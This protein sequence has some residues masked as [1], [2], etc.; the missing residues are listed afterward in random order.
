MALTKIK[1]TGLDTGITDN[2]DANAITIDSSERVG[3]GTTGPATTLEV[4]NDSPTNGVQLSLT[5]QGVGD[6]GIGFLQYGANSAVIVNPSGTNDIAF[7][8][9]SYHGSRGNEKMRI[10]LT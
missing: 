4:W 9:N 10:K 7:E 2:S 3:I 8:N 5:R 1:R 6:V